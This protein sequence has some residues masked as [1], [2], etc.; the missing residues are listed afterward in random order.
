M[1]I[2]EIKNELLCLLDAAR[3]ADGEFDADTEAAFAE[4]AAGLREAFADKADSYAAL[5]RTCQH[6]ADARRAEAKRMVALADSDDAL[7][8]R[9]SRI[10]LEAMQATG[11]TKVDTERF[12]LSA[13]ANG[14]KLPVV[15]SDEKALPAQYRVPVYTEKVDRD[16]IRTALEAGT[17]VPGASLGQRGT[18]LDI[19]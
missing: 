1:S 15:L 6:R 2:Y 12:R 14:G 3:N 19:R 10:L 11:L 8:D 17:E 5:I 13:R 18:R 16:A 9:L 4:H 7:A